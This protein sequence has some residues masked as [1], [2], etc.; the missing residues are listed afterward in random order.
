MRK[1]IVDCDGTPETLKN[2]RRAGWDGVFFSYNDTEA[3]QK[4]AADTKR[5]NLKIQSVHAPYT[6]IWRLWEDAGEGGIEELN[7]QIACI[8]ATA[9]I[10]VNL[11]I[12]HAIIGMERNTPTELGVEQFGK[13]VRAAKDAG[14]RLALENTEG[15]P[16]LAA[17]MQAYGDDPT[18]GFCIDT[19]HE[20]CY[21]H[22]QDMIGKYGKKKV[23]GTHLNDNMGVTGK[24]ITWLDDAHM[25]PFD[26]I[27]DW[28]GIAARLK[29]AE[30]QGDLTFELIQ[31]NRPERHTND[32]YVS[33]SQLEFYTLA[34]EHA[35]RFAK[36]ME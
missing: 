17:L 19:G 31:G 2:I 34:H 7:E 23:F 6:G 25:L 35:M 4:T 27:A 8:R 36:M 12:L 16:Y 11:V 15:E 5:E 20:L 24:S 3:L 1:L 32:R 9:G 28:N 10:G 29:R 33:L 14:V 26:G 13:I 18:V 22:A 21:N 30:F